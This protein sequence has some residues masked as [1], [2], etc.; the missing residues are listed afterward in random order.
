MLK[1][2]AHGQICSKHTQNHVLKYAQVAKFV[3]Y[4]NS[5]NGLGEPKNRAQSQMLRQ[6]MLALEEEKINPSKNFR[7]P[8]FI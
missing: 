3:G 5:V 4:N 8:K 7:R 2:N 6:S 1:T